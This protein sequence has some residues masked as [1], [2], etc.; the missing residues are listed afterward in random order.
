MDT[1]RPE[2][3]SFFGSR[4]SGGKRSGSISE[5][6]KADGK[7]KA[8]KEKGSADC[9]PPSEGHPREEQVSAMFLMLIVVAYKTPLDMLLKPK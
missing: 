3:G 6:T 2:S 8:E 4:I 5:V 9:S 1:M 7:R